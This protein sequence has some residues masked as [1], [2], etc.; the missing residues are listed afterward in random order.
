MNKDAHFSVHHG[1]RRGFSITFQNGYRVSVQFA[2][3]NCCENYSL[4]IDPVTVKE[5]PT[6]WNHS[7][8]AEVAVLSPSGGAIYMYQNQDDQILY[9]VTPDLLSRII[10]RVSEFKGVDNRYADSC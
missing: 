1:H 10:Q 2:P 5:E 8:N 3:T 9:D 7:S 6:N 4:D